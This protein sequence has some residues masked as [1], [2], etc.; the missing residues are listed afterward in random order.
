MKAKGFTLIEL[1]IVV[2][3]IGILAAIAIPA[4]QGYITRSQVNAHIDNKD[5]AVRFVRNEFAKGVAGGDCNYSNI[6]TFIDELNEGG[7]LAVG[8]AS[9]DAF[10]E[11]GAG[12][13]QVL[14]TVSS[15]NG[16]TGCPDVNASVTVDLVEITNISSDY[17]SAATAS[18]TFQLD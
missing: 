11:T 14:V 7:K 12:A 1:M 18:I 10:I 2:A 3:I 16:T 4:Y 5:I 13:G 8:N 9:L 17:P 6:A 15:F